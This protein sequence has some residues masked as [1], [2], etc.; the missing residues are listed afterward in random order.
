MKSK[1][2]LLK[3]HR[4]KETVKGKFKKF[5]QEDKEIFDEFSEKLGCSENILQLWLTKLEDL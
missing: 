2:F 1:D 5:L 4:F 3:Q